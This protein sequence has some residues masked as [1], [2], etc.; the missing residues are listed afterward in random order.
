MSIDPPDMFVEFFHEKHLLAKDTSHAL[1]ANKTPDEKL[2]VAS[3]Q[4]CVS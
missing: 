1:G 3:Q 4:L 2:M